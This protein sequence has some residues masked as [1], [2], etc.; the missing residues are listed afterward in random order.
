M[1]DDARIWHGSRPPTVWLH[2]HSLPFCQPLPV[3]P[4]YLCCPAEET[5]SQEICNAH[6]DRGPNRRSE[7]YLI[8]FFSCATAFADKPE[9][10]NTRRSNTPCLPCLLIL[11]VFPEAPLHPANKA[12]KLGITSVC[13][14]YLF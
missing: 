12:E 9:V 11:Q 14:R 5:Q 8:F 4:G 10:K 6:Q 1:K 13:G 7:E 3:G 2:S